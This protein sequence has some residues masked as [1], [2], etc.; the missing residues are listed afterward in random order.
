MRTRGYQDL[1]CSY[2]Q[3]DLSRGIFALEDSGFEVATTNLVKTA[4]D[5]VY[6]S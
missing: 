6:K 5:L 3:L 2:V 1:T 4:D